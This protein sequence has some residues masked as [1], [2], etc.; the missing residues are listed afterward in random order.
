MRALFNSKLRGL[1]AFRFYGIIYR[2]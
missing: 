2:T 1:Q